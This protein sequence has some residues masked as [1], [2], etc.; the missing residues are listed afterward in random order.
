MLALINLQMYIYLIMYV[1][2]ETPRLEARRDALSH[3][4]DALLFIL[5]LVLQNIV[6]Y[7]QSFSTHHKGNL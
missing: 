1:L 4:T 5:Y 2:N 7:N 3:F 6:N